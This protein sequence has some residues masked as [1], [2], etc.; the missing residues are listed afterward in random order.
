MF[1]GFDE[2]KQ[3]WS[4]LPH[5]F[6]N[7]WDNIETLAEMRV[8][9][10][11]LRHTWGYSEY[12]KPK[13]I[14]IDEFVSGRK[15]KD[16]SRLDG[17]IGMSKPSVVDGLKRAEDHGFIEVAKNDDDKAR[18]R[19]LYRLSMSGLK[20]L[21]PEPEGGGK[22]VLHRTE[23]ETSSKETLKTPAATAGGPGADAEA[24]PTYTP[25]DMAA[26]E[27]DLMDD[28]ILP[29]TTADGYGNA[30]LAFAEAMKLQDDVY[31]TLKERIE[32]ETDVEAADIAGETT[33]LLDA[34][35]EDATADG[36]PCEDTIDAIDGA[37]MSN[38][39][40]TATGTI[41][42]EEG[43]RAYD[44]LHLFS[45]NRAPFGRHPVQG[46]LRRTWKAF[47]RRQS[48]RQRSASQRQKS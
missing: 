27:Q 47:R 37:L 17:G 8:I 31:K 48:F 5:A 9:L 12:D 1:E 29:T 36:Q 7:G 16:G 13:R 25:E 4:K 10:Y 44:L 32:R 39:R 19:K 22:E 34:M 6:I 40:E 38:I 33:P 23:K 45:I 26:A 11:I 30:G 14:T 42:F 18:V 41:T 21:T 15:R 35:I 2:P 43:S 3:N 24:L 46:L 28:G 20:G